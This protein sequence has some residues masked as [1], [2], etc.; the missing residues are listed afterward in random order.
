MYRMTLRQQ[1]DVLA[2][3]TLT[4]P[5]DAT[6][7]AAIVAAR[8]GHATAMQVLEIRRGL[9]RWAECGKGIARNEAQRALA[10]EDEDK[11]VRWYDTGGKR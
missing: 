10:E 9:Q 6:R 8:E 2:R 3:I 11:G 1:A 4:A 7:S 5:P